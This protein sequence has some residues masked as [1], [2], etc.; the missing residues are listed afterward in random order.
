MMLPRLLEERVRLRA[1]VRCD[2]RED[3][4]WRGG[5]DDLLE[6]EAPERRRRRELVQFPPE[7]LPVGG[8]SSSVCSADPLPSNV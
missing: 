7:R 8:S 3:V 1:S 6:F 4:L 5:I 2:R